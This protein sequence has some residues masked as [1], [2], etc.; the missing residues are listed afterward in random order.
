MPEAT[1]KIGSIWYKEEASHPTNPKET[2]LVDRLAYLGD[3]VELSDAEFERLTQLD[4]LYTEEELED[5]DEV[6]FS[7]LSDADLIDWI[8]EEGP[9]VNEVLDAS[10]GDPDLARRLLDAE[11]A[12]TEGE[13]RKGVVEGLSAVISRA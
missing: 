13:P 6:P 7:D 8:T 2:M 11:E 10:D 12:A 9:T 3:E 4:A 5:G 1:V